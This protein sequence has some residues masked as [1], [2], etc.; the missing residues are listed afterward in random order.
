MRP[1]ANPNKQDTFNEATANP[2]TNS[3]PDVLRMKD[4]TKVARPD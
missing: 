4:G 1:G 2:Y 3:M